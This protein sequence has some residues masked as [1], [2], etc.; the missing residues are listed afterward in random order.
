[1]EYCFNSGEEMAWRGV[2]RKPGKIIQIE[3]GLSN[4]ALGETCDLGLDAF[5]V[6]TLLE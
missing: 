3:G 2:L 5:A 1:L 6:K 4:M